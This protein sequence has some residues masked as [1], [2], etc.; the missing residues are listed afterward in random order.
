MNIRW[1][2]LVFKLY[3]QFIAWTSLDGIADHPEGR[4]TTIVASVIRWAF[5]GF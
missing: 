1:N 3:V 5:T 2:D 4:T